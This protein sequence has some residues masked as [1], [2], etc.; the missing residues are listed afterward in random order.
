[1]STI[2]KLNTLVVMPAFNEQESIAKVI[3]EV[4]KYLPNATL[5]VVDDGS[6]DSTHQVARESGAIVATLPFNL[7]VGGAMRLGYKYARNNNFDCLVQIDADGQ[8]DPQDVELLIKQLDEFDLVLGS[9]FAG[10]GNYQVSGPRSWAMN[11]LSKS[12]SAIC[13][14]QLTDTT[15]GFKASGRKAIA[16]FSENFPAEYLGDTVEALVIASKT[17][18]RITEVPVT[19][20]ARSGGKP[21]NSPA[22]ATIHLFRAC[23]AICFSLISPKKN[24]IIRGNYE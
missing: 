17:G 10:K 12:L 6:K 23:T 16:I 1:M 3:T 5:L 15:S 14:T 20:R 13:K 24:L 21:S 4:Q 9:R 19:M 8:H 18:L 2:D 22:K 7:G 11:I